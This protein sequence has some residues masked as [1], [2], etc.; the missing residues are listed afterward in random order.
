MRGKGFG[1]G[2]GAGLVLGLIVV[3]IS[4]GAAGSSLGM[5][6]SNQ[7]AVS[8]NPTTEE[9]TST[10]TMPATEN[11][12]MGVPVASV[13]STSTTTFAA[14]SNATTVAPGPY[15]VAGVTFSNNGA[16]NLNSLP[17]QSPLADAVV[18]VPVIVALLLGA[19]LYRAYRVSLDEEGSEKD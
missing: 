4:S 16:T 6:G 10:T 15:S 17:Q 9:V 2:I 13:T 1:V 3:G 11:S 12:S 14:A 18:F 19:V 8:R 5:F 7:A